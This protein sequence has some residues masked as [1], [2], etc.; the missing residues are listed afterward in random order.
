MCVY[1]SWAFAFHFVLLFPI[2][3]PIGCLSSWFLRTLICWFPV[4]KNKNKTKN[5]VLWFSASPKATWLAYCFTGNI[6]ERLVYLSLNVDS[7]SPSIDSSILWNPAVGKCCSTDVF[8][9]CRHYWWPPNF[10]FTLSLV[11]STCHYL[12]LST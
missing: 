10:M 12:T 4:N 7:F 3:F 11:C 5:H 6:S 1:I 9:S 8:G 2:F